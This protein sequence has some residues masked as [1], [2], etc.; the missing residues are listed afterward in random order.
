MSNALRLS[1]VFALI[2]AAVSAPVTAAPPLEPDYVPASGGWSDQAPKSEAADGYMRARTGRLSFKDENDEPHYCTAQLISPRNSGSATLLLTAAHCARQNFPVDEYSFTSD[3]TTA[4]PVTVTV[5]CVTRNP[6]WK[7]P[8]SYPNHFDEFINARLDYAFLKINETSIPVYFQVNWAQTWT[9]TNPVSNSTHISVVGYPDPSGTGTVP[10][11]TLN[12]GNL[13]VRPDFY[14]RKLNAISTPDV[15]FT[16]G[17][18]GGAW[19]NIA[20]KIV[21]IT[22]SYMGKTLNTG[23]GDYI[24]IFGPMLHDDARQLALFTEGAQADGDG[25]CVQ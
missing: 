21:S 4:Q 13:E 3:D 12:L 19:I 23:V 16:K 10:L 11:S 6:N 9:D 1:A 17:T 18:S 2:C 8:S 20:K 5:E 22:S 24:T 25:Q 15:T 14:H 7:D